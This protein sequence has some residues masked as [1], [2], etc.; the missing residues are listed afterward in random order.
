MQGTPTE[1]R[2]AGADYCLFYYF[3]AGFQICSFVNKSSVFLSP[4]FILEVS[5]VLFFF[6]LSENCVLPRKLSLTKPHYANTMR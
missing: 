1:T 3:P 5:V 4:E 6:F 2:R